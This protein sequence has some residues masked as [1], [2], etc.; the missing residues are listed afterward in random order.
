MVGSRRLYLAWNNSRLMAGV[1]HAPLLDLAYHFR[2]WGCQQLWV[3]S[4]PLRA[5]QAFNV[6][7]NVLPVTERI[8]FSLAER[9]T[10][11][12][13]VVGKKLK[14]LG[15]QQ[16]ATPELFTY[17]ENQAEIAMVAKKL[18]K[19]E[20]LLS[21]IQG[22]LFFSEEIEKFLN[23]EGIAWADSLEDLMQL[24]YLQG[25]VQILPSVGVNSD[26]DLQ[27][28]R[29]G[30]SDKLRQAYC[31]VCESENCYY[32]ENCVSMGESRQCRVFYAVP[33]LEICAI[34][35]KPI[36]RLDFQLTKAQSDASDGVLEFVVGSAKVKCLVWA[37]C[38]AGKTEVVFA[39]IREALSY[40]HK[41]LFAVPRRDT[42]MDIQKR[43]KKA[44]SGIEIAVLYGGSEERFKSA[45]LVVATTHQ[46]LRFY[47][48]F[49]LVILDEVDAFPYHEDMLLHGILSR[50]VCAGGKVIYM[51]ATPPNYLLKESIKE[52]ERVIIPARH[53]GYPLPVPEMFMCKAISSKTEELVIPGDVLSFL[54][55]S[56]RDELAQV[57]IFVAT[58]PLAEKT[59]NALKRL[60]GEEPFFG[61]GENW[62]RFV[63]SRDSERDKKRDGFLNGEFPIL[64]A[65][66]VMERGITIKRV[67]VL[68]LFAEN[69]VIFDTRTLVQLAGRAGRTADYPRG[70]V[71]F[72]GN[73]RTSEM[74]EAVKWIK[75][76][77]A[78]AL[79]RGY[80]GQEVD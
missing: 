57:L 28:F 58:I 24:G 7:S 25:L 15:I 5:A 9:L 56:V 34:K 17:A 18:A 14:K 63:H 42:V 61:Y 10:A 48:A 35:R 65:T 75:N 71:W 69:T 80:L 4:P 12:F 11:S 46:V 52:I 70:K 40:G 53:H 50:A 8:N 49:Q 37:A 26:G 30:D 33:V 6:L 78:E 64:V 19:A 2:T 43:I 36:V 59:T 39:A 20:A 16:L 55:H 68:V 31:L 67:N 79:A 47:K 51:T 22:R 54:Q 74:K 38:G 13:S 76:V 41:V 44:F 62:V 66:T 23:S 3:I 21:V 60:L 32:C 45:D 72:V 77:N 27:C 29:C 1:S 73:R